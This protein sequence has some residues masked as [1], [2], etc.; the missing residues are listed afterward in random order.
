MLTKIGLNGKRHY[1]PWAPAEIFVGGGGWASPQK[2]P[3]MEIKVAE[4]PP[5][6]EKESPK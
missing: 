2:G 3:T 5:H 1:N 4:R 6:G